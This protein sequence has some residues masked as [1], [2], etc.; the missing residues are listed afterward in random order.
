[1]SAEHVP[2]DYVVEASVIASVPLEGT[3]L[4]T[5]VSSVSAEDG[6]SE[7]VT[8]ISGSTILVIEGL[9]Q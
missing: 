6:T 9:Q 4:S 1:M 2:S 5:Q 3:A 8:D 7:T